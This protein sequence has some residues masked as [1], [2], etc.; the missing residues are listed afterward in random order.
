MKKVTKK[1]CGL[2]LSVILAFSSLSLNAYAAEEIP[3]D[4]L[5]NVSLSEE[6]AQDEAAL[7]VRSEDAAVD[8]TA[9]EDASEAESA[10][11]DL[12]SEDISS[13]EDASDVD[14]SVT[15]A[16]DLDT[17]A[18]DSTGEVKEYYTVRYEAIDEGVYDLPV[19]DTHYSYGDTVQVVSGEPSRVG[20]DFWGWSL[21][22]DPSVVYTSEWNF[23]IT[24]DVTFYATWSSEEEKAL[25]GSSSKKP[26]EDGVVTAINNYVNSLNG[27]FNPYF[28]SKYITSR[29]CCA[30]CDYVWQ[31]VLGISRGSDPRVHKAITSDRKLSEGEIYEFLKANDVKPGDW[32]WCHNPYSAVNYQTTHNM[33]ILGYDSESITVSD[34]YE[35]NGNSKSIHSEEEWKTIWDKEYKELGLDIEK[36]NSILTNVY[37]DCENIN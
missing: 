37:I 33:I 29:Q 9:V 19:D 34:G 13:D 1:L 10:D 27:S 26:K 7:D 18:S 3:Q 22:G 24:G 28:S 2:A 12:S 11:E 14:A 21:T 5:E 30:F 25:V 6:D 4:Y 20:Y 15:D 17:S 23:E 31:D 8:D 35:K 32:L 16:S 36:L